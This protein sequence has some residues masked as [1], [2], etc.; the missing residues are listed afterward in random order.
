MAGSSFANWSAFSLRRWI[1]YFVHRSSPKVKLLHDWAKFSLPLC[2]RLTS[3]NRG[4]VY[5][6]TA[7]DRVARQGRVGVES[8]ETTTPVRNKDKWWKKEYYVQWTRLGI[9]S[10]ADGAILREPSWRESIPLCLSKH[11]NRLKMSFAI[12]ANIIHRN[13]LSIALLGM[14]VFFHYCLIV[15]CIE[16]CTA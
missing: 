3:F 9:S 7:T 13:R 12:R 11:W 8:V 15:W 16:L 10:T 6:L 4:T 5:T 2:E 14:V 1:S